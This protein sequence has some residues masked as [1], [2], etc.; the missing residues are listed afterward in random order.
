MFI[1]FYVER[2]YAHAMK[3]VQRSEDKGTN[4]FSTN[5]KGP[6]IK[7]RMP[8]LRVG[9]LPAERFSGSFYLIS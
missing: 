7:C 1:Y 8:G 6:E 9:T 2:S 3:L 5:T 4:Q